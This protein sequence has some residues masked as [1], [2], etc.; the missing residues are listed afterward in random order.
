MKTFAKYLFW[1]TMAGIVIGSAGTLR[2][3]ADPDGGNQAAINYAAANANMVCSKLDA[4]P[5]ID[6]VGDVGL[7][8]NQHSH[9]TLQQAGIVI[10]LSVNNACPCHED[11]LQRFVAKYSTS[12]DNAVMA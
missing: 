1:A 6:G 8:I 12:I 10:G 3:H 5:T 9:L 2:A 7:Y 4:E 11:L